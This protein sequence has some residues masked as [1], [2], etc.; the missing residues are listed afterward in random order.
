MTAMLTDSGLETWLVF[1]RNVELPDVAAVPWLDDA[2]GGALLVGVL[3]RPP[4]P[5]PRRGS[6]HGLETPTRRADPD[7]GARL[8]YDAVALDRV[9]RDAVAFV[10]ELADE[11]HGVNVVVSGNIGPRRDG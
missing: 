5:G 9:N 3:P 4:S 11:I 6:R 2:Q 7:W 1:H 8:G 10:R